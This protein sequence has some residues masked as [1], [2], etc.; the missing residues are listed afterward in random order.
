MID[1]CIKQS[2]LMEDHDRFRRD[3][4]LY[5]LYALFLCLVPVLTFKNVTCVPYP[6]LTKIKV[7]IETSTRVCF[8]FKS[9]L[10]CSLYALDATF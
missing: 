8:L 10:V 1:G 6:F 2:Q 3:F 4:D 7:C 9:A 5:L